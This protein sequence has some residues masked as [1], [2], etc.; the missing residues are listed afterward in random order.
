MADDGYDGYAYSYPHKTAYRPLDPPVALDES[1]RD[2]DTS[3]LFL[4][5]HLPFCE[6]RCGFCNLFTTVRPGQDLVDRTLLAIERQAAEVARLVAPRGV[7]QAAVGGGTPSF[8]SEAQL[9]RLFVAVGASWP[10]RWGQTPLSLEVS[11]GTVT[12]AKL[13]LLRALGVTRLSMGVQSFLSEDLA[14]LHRPEL[15]ADLDEVCGWIRDAR[16][17]VFN[18]DL[19][20]GIEG[21]DQARWER[22]LSAALR[23]LPEELY[24]YPLYVG[25]LTSLDRLGRRPGEQRR[26]LYRQARRRLLAAG[27]EQVSM[28][29]FRRQGVVDVGDYC[30]QEDGMVGLGP[31]A[32][33]YTR[34]LH[35]SSEYAVGQPGV[36]AIISAFSGA[37]YGHASY[38][39]RLDAAEQRRR[40]L[41]K[42]L[43]RAQGLDVVG[44]RQ[45]FGSDPRLDFPSL[46][47]LA[48]LGLA[49]LGEE[50]LALTELGLA[51]TDTIGPWLYSEAVQARMGEYEL[52]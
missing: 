4:Y 45:R 33:S 43:L 2:E 36:R 47:E 41:L 40:Y 22:S 30:C 17:P 18:M 10:V 1:W 49:N 29:L 8:L 27:Y 50:R 32:R 48:D 46:S 44:Y 12:P 9:E 5:L 35:Y 24:L 52:C 26:A 20:Y 13:A 7:A 3:A 23:W 15:G 31:G 39:V 16:F 34:D 37:D 14:A 38:G 11:P 19:I 51:Y 21:Q 6:M 42:S 25:K 28:R